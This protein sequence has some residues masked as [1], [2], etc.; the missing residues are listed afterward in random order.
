MKAT[1]R[2][3][4]WMALCG[5]LALAGCGDGQGAQLSKTQ[6]ALKPPDQSA[7]MLDKPSHSTAPRAI[8][9]AEL[10]RRNLWY[11]VRLVD[12]ETGYR[13]GYIRGQFRMERT[14]DRGVTWKPI[15]LP[16]A[17]RLSDQSSYKSAENPQVAVVDLDTVALYG[18]QGNRF[19]RLTTFDGGRR[20]QVA[21]SE[22][23]HGGYR[24]TSVSQPTRKDAWVVL[25]APAL[26]GRAG[27]LLCRVS[28]AGA[29]VA[30][31][32]VD[33]SAPGSG[34]MPG[35]EI[36]VSF[37]NL[38]DGYVY[39]ANPDGKLVAYQTR[40]GGVHFERRAL[41]APAPIA[42]AKVS[43][44]FPPRALEQEVTFASI[45]RT[46]SAAG[47]RHHVVVFRTRDGGDSYAGQ[48]C[49]VLLGARANAEGAPC[50]FVTP[51]YGYAIK[52]GRLM[53]TSDS[54]TTWLTVHSTTLEQ[55]LDTYPCVLDVDYVSYTQGFVLAANASLTQTVLLATQGLRDRFAPVR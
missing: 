1:R 19:V 34:F 44:L 24:V 42:G 55:W 12:G 35:A 40:D 11:H 8:S 39:A 28:D 20:W 30:Q 26:A 54:G 43:H 27:P 52:D 50:A 37:A 5:V 7:A 38:R 47:V 3:L 29:R 53:R 13:Y 49:D 16:V 41:S 9:L 36:E 33:P 21:S 6:S 10:Q 23:P 45:W 17:F 32:K 22:L 18:V 2:T 25:D 4:A 14:T 48:V 51:D 31:V 15:S 46:K